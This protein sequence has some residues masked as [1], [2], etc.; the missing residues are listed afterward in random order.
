MLTPG[1]RFGPYEIIAAVGSGGMGEVYRAHD[2]RL[3]RVVALKVLPQALTA[4]SQALQRFEREA[5]AIAALNHPNI[6]TIHDVGEGP[7][8]TRFIVM[9]LLEGETLRDRLDRGPL[10]SAELV[11]SAIALAGGLDAAHRRGIVHRDIKPSNIFLTPH[12]PKLLD[13]GLALPSTRSMTGASQATTI[14]AMTEVGSTVGTVAYMSPEQ[15]RAEPLDART[16]LFSLGAVLYEMA[17]GRPAFPGNTSAVIA[18][19]ILEKT[20]PP[21]RHGKGALPDDLARIVDRALEKDRELRYQSAADLRSELERLGRHSRTSPVDARPRPPRR[22]TLVVGAIVAAVVLGLSGVAYRFLT[23]ASA[24]TSL[25]VLPFTHDSREP[26]TEYLSSG[27]TENLIN[28]LSQSGVRVLSR[29]TVLPY[30]GREIDPRVAGRELQ[31]D[32]VLTGRVTPQADMLDIQAELVDVATGAQLWGRHYTRPLSALL[33][34]QD[35]ILRDLSETLRLTRTAEDERRIAQRYPD[36]TDAYRLYLRGRY[37]FDQRTADGTR[38]AIE[39]FEEAI[40]RDPNYALAHAGLA[41]AYVP[42]DTV[43]PPRDNVA[44]AKSA[45]VKALASNNSLAEVQT[46]VGRVLQHCD[47]DWPGAERAFKR[48]IELDPRNAEAHHMYSHYLVPMGRVDESVNEAR[49]ALALDPLDVLLNVHLAWAY[50]HARRYDESMQQ[51][52]KAVAMDPNLEVARTGLGRA[53]LGKQMYKEA[54]AEFEK[55]ATLAAGVATGPDTYIGYTSAVMGMHAEARAKLEIL[56]ERHQQGKAT[57]HDVAVLYAGL[58]DRGQALDWMER[59]YEE[60]SGGLLQ[61]KAD[62]IFDSIRSDPRFTDLLRRLGLPT[63]EQ[64]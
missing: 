16:D 49:L 53:Y 27:I 8:G 43:L 12:G 24:I 47:W 54:L 38:R 9:E 20:P 7:S 4:D 17:A 33:T 19:A 42:S 45:A 32:G 29:N 30:R 13:F 48:A 37:Y 21:L 59:A 25:A 57:A 39:S 64:R 41:N 40:K 52:L 44:R 3:D 34:V 55:I 28:N 11:D 6:C 50:L 5:R 31:V 46:A 56:R 22:R 15:L 10:D 58:N 36:N 51:S 23:S 62:P 18:N 61:I 26:N 35:E 60:R 2:V 1:L 14:G 63:A